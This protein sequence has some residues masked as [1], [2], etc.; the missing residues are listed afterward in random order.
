MTFCNMV[1]ALCVCGCVF[2]GMCE[3]AVGMKVE[4][5]QQQL[6]SS[7]VTSEKMK[8][9]LAELATSIELG[10]GRLPNALEN[11]MP[12]VDNLLL[13]NSQIDSVLPYCNLALWAFFN[14]FDSV[15]SYCVSHQGDEP[16][17]NNF[18]KF[19]QFVHAVI[20]HLQENGNF[21]NLEYKI[22][23]SFSQIVTTRLSEECDFRM[24]ELLEYLNS[25]NSTYEW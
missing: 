23:T 22:P 24:D 1:K 2:G 17:C 7:P 12:T 15:A 16:F 8:R 9:A 5:E 4:T 14:W 10:R 20:K 25:L 3:H 13:D 6:D 11:I 18:D 19:I 21:N